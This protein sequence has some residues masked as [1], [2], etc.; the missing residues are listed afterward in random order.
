MN[1]HVYN[2][3]TP[4]RENFNSLLHYMPFVNELVYHKINID[5]IIISPLPEL[6]KGII[7]KKIFQ[8]YHSISK[9]PNEIYE[10]IKQYAPEYEHIVFD[11]DMALPF[12]YTYFNK[13]VVDTFLNLYG[14]HRSDLLRYCLI[15]V[16]GGVYLDIKTELICPLSSLLVT[17]D[18]YT[19]L[20]HSPVMIGTIYQ[21]IIAT[22]P[23]MPFF[24][25]LIQ[26]IVKIGEVPKINYWLF[27][28][29][30][31]NKIRDETGEHPKIGQNNG[32]YLWEDRCSM[33][34]GKCYDGLDRYGT[35]CFVY[36]K[37]IP[38]IKTRRA[39]YPW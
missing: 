38:I 27:C 14:A 30:F 22:P 5:E 26:F 4:K 9:I 32:F 19:V 3:N 25:K 16:Y 17:N 20:C 36:D 31:Y 18:I 8:T 33:D 34:P 37:D 11:D 10:N 13:K 21:G 15:Y 2:F 35:C 7:T 1:Y 12:L 28:I 24:L 39:S 6:R 29:D 23:Q